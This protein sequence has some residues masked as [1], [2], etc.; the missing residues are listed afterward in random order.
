MSQQGLV[1]DPQDFARRGESL[2]GSVAL[3]QLSRLAD[4]LSGTEGRAQYAVFGE[5]DSEG[6]L[7][8]RLH[9]E[10]ALHLQCQRCLGPLDWP[11][12]SEGRLHLIPPGRAM[13][14]EDLADDESDPVAVSGSLDVLPLLEDEILLA[15]PLIPRHEDCEAP[16]FSDDTGDTSAFAVLGTLKQ[17]PKR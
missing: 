17:R 9:V 5:S 16:S 11:L 15:L 7:Y 10:A 12:E 1:I 13:P 8:L 4:V 2:E 14:D 3:A 6:E